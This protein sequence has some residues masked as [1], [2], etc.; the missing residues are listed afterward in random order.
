MS[1][2]HVGRDMRKGT[3]A[4]VLPVRPFSLPTPH[5]VILTRALY[6]KLRILPAHKAF[7]ASSVRSVASVLC[8]RHSNR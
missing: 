8:H 4:C 1:L 2:N 6:S 3:I 5:Q 7:K